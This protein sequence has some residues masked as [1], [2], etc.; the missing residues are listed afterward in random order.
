[1][2][3]SIWT[4]VALITLLLTVLA[5]PARSTTTGTWTGTVVYVN[6]AHIGVK[7]Q[8]QTRDFILDGDTTY[9]T[10]GKKASH[11][12]IENGMMVTVSFTQR[13]LFGSTRA[14]R[15]D[16]SSFALPLPTGS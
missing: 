9:Y 16:T 7:S 11:S 10:N 6:N 14:T 3:R 2:I 15:I 5:I 8:A 1:M 13:T 12:S 4:C